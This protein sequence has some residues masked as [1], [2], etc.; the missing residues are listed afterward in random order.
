MNIDKLEAGRELDALV[1]KEKMGWH[2]EYARHITTGEVIGWWKEPEYLLP[3]GKE[4]AEKVP[5]YSTSMTAAESVITSVLHYLAQPGPRGGDGW[6]RILRES[7]CLRG[8]PDLIPGRWICRFILSGK[9]KSWMG[10][11][12][13]LPLAICRAALKVYLEPQD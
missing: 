4:D 5:Q 2:Q 10:S 7:A 9:K 8:A 1:A 13:D 3:P 6:C 12:D 11:A